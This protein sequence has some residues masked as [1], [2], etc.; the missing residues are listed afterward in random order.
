MGEIKGGIFAIKSQVRGLNFS[1]KKLPIPLSFHT[2]FKTY[3]PYYTLLRLKQVQ[4]NQRFKFLIYKIKGKARSSSSFIETIKNNEL[5]NVT[6][7]APV[8]ILRTSY[9]APALMK[10]DCIKTFLLSCPI[11]SLHFNVIRGHTSCRNLEFSL[12]KCVSWSHP[13]PS[14]L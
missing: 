10:C 4:A 1:L 2:A 9:F 6:T 14:S 11:P 7:S 12:N 3:G 13:V 5:K 8:V